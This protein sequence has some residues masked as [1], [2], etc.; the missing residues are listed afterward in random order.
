MMKQHRSA[1]L[2]F[3]PVVYLAAVL[4]PLG[5]APAAWAGAAEE[6]AAIGQH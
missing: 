5:I 1:K 3:A 4:S 2:G 6:I